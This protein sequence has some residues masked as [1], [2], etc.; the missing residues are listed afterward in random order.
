M[1]NSLSRVKRIAFL[2]EET[3]K[4]ALGLFALGFGLLVFLSGGKPQFAQPD[5]ADKL[6]GPML[7]YLGYC[8]AG[9]SLKRL[10]QRKTESM[11]TIDATVSAK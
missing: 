10:I 7:A 3:L 5:F 8:L 6:S 4:S 2:A 1:T 9:P 11:P